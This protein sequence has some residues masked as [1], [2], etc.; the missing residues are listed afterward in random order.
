MIRALESSGWWDKIRAVLGNDIV[1][2]HCSSVMLGSFCQL[3]VGEAL[4]RVMN[5]LGWRESS[6]TLLQSW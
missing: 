1:L 4:G 6:I 2:I 3:S 5:P